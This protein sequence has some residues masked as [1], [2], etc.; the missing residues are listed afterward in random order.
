[1]ILR[2]YSGRSA[3]RLVKKGILGYQVASIFSKHYRERVAS[4]NV[5][6]VIEGFPRSANTYGE[7][8]FRMM[9]S[10]PVRVGHHLHAAGQISFAVKHGIP[11]I[12]L[13]REPFPAIAS[14][15]VRSPKLGP[16]DAILDYLQI[17]STI[18][19]NCEKLI[20]S[21]FE[22][23]TKDFGSIINLVN[24]QFGTE[25]DCA[26]PPSVSEQDVLMEIERLDVLNSGGD[27]NMVARPS[28]ERK[29]KALEIS[30]LLSSSRE[31]APLMHK[32]SDVYNQIIERASK[33]RSRL[34]KED[35]SVTTFSS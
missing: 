25:F 8:S 31:L 17:N 11:C 18:L 1:M 10:R 24:I 21:P 23:T 33:N 29:T 14:L 30:S 2:I 19:H 7:V 4:K 12:A 3:L 27:E 9:Q 32:A 26:L 15:I 35:P 13:I 28:S 5:D 34:I 22:C 20:V 16:R 6:I